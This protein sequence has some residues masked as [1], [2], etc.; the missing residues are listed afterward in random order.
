M[1][2]SSQIRPL[3]TPRYAAGDV[4]A[5]KYRLESI[6]G[7]GGMGT[8][9]HAFNLQ[10]EAPVALKLIRAELDRE[11]HT[12]R[13]KQEARAAAK[14]GHPGIVRVFDVGDSEF[15]D[16]FIV[17]ELLHGRSLSALLVAEHRMAAV[18][19][20]QLL[21]PVADALSV[22]HAKGIVHRDLKPDNIFLAVD[23]EQLQPKLVDFGIVKLAG[24]GT[25]DK[26]LTQAG[27]V[28]GS[29]EYMSPEQARGREDLDHRTDIWSFCIVLYETV[30]GVTPFAGVNYNALLRSIVEDEPP[31]L[32]AYLASDQSLWEIIR[33]GL[34]KDVEQRYRSMGELGRALAAWLVRQGIKED[35]CGGSLDSKWVNRTSDPLAP[36]VSRASF[37]SLSGFAPESGVRDSRR[38]N[39]ASA[40]TLGMGLPIGEPTIPAPAP[41][42]H[43]LTPMRGAVL[44]G[45]LIVLIGAVGLLTARGGN[46]S[47]SPQPTAEAAPRDPGLLAAPRMPPSVTPSPDDSAAKSQSSA[48]VPSSA[49]AHQGLAAP[50]P[51]KRSPGRSVPAPAAPPSVKNPAGSSPGDLIAPY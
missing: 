27:T 7:E 19:A 41:R 32:M 14:L 42:S 47:P 20:V 45:A 49:A 4:I 5:G 11:V 24:Q 37:A 6:L 30:A 44:L 28:L 31:S 1:A 33:R 12:Q 17:M 39:L 40:P 10:L 29:P 16:P 21:L 9:W 50:R 22:A 43:W 34:A 35:V 51:T 36:R 2:T 48:Q 15:G 46:V 25:T 26:H 13:L 23:E 18:H 38:E 8:V 3:G